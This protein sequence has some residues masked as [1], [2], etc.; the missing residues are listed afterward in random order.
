MLSE[1]CNW[2]GIQITHPLSNSLTTNSPTNYS[3]KV[4]HSRTRPL[5][6]S[7][8]VQVAHSQSRP[9]SKSPTKTFCFFCTLLMKNMINIDKYCDI[10][11]QIKASIVSN[12][13]GQKY[14]TYSQFWKIDK[15]FYHN[16]WYILTPTSLWCHI[17]NHSVLMVWASFLL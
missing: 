15:L 13:V 10:W 17:G 11:Y 7:P 14:L 16:I 3:G 9:L 5:S 4:V 12:T 2:N 8:T 6:K 1:W